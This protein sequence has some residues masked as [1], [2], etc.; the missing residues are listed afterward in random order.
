MMST[1]ETRHAEPYLL[2]RNA[3]N[4]SKALYYRNDVVLGNY[5]ER[6]FVGK[7]VLGS[8]RYAIVSNISCE[9]SG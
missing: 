5:F 6:I 3:T 4:K 9:D 1:A 7:K 2:Q 8:L